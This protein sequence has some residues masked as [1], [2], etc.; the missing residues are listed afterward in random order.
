MILRR[1]FDSYEAYVRTQGA[2]ARSR[3]AELL[4]SRPAQARGFS[5]HVREALRFLPAAGPV[6]CLGARTGAE[7]VSGSGRVFSLRPRIGRITRK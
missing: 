7:M 5:A 2:K 4:A 6:L 1:E 3:G